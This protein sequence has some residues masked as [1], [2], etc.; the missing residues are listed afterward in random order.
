VKPKLFIVQKIMP[1][2]LEALK[3]HAEVEVFEKERMI[4]RDELK[5]GIA[6]SDFLLMLG[7]VPI[8][9]DIMDANPDLRGIVVMT[10]NP[11][12]VDIDAATE[13]GIPVTNIDHV[14]MTTTCDLT[15]AHILGLAWRLVEADRFTR[16]GRFRQE[17]S[18]TFLCH[19]LPGKVLGLIGLGAIGK[20]IAKRARAFEMKVV[21]TKNTRLGL[22]E[23]AELGV[24]WVDDKD[25]V[26]RQADFVSLMASYNP[27]THLMIGEREF[28]LMKPTAFFINT[29]RGRI[30][31][32]EAMLA[33]LREGRIAGAGLDVYWTEPPVGEPAPPE[34]LFKMD[35][36]ILTPHI[37]SA[38]HESRAKMAAMAADNAIALIKGERPKN[39]LN[40]ETLEPATA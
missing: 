7:D 27:S 8:D 3:E 18:M 11:N 37:G 29:A 33:A 36:V 23:E 30:V 35:N 10:M 1:D 40:P 39:L 4:S 15:M 25:D 2:A 38:T 13:R 9:G 14:I 31:D 12:V 5:A 21:Y 16:S 28:G 20:E 24:E 34:E 22:E 32:E 26:L 6:R 17:Q 19:A